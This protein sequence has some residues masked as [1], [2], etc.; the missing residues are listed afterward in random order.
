MYKDKLTKSVA[1]SV[2]K[3]MQEAEKNEN[4][5]PFEG[6]KKVKSSTVV[7]KSGAVHSP[8]SRVKHLA[9]LA[10]QKKKEVKEDVEQIDE[11]SSLDQLHS[12]HKFVFNKTAA[13]K[14]REQDRNREELKQ[15]IKD[16]KRLG[17]IAGPKTKLPEE[18]EQ[19]DELSLGTKIKAYA[20]RSSRQYD[21]EEHGR[22]PEKTRASIVK[23]HGEKAGAHADA[24]ADRAIFGRAPK[25]KVK[26]EVEV[27]EE[28][29]GNQHKI[30]MNKNNKVDAHDFKLLRS[31][32][33]VAEENEE[34]EEMTE[35]WNE[36]MADVKRRHA[37]GQSNFE[38]KKISTGTVYQRKHEGQKEEPTE[39]KKTK[40]VKKYSEMV[41]IIRDKGIKGLDEAFEVEEIVEEVDQIEEQVENQIEERTLTEPEA[42]EKEKIVKGMKKKLS[43]FKDRYGDRAKEV[44]YATATARAK[45]DK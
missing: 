39:T 4:K 45:E 7:D 36:M 29:K 2:T 27:S 37:E 5:P 40:K 9:R 41:E 31:K 22:D 24:A 33:K 13:G 35:G 17:G 43:S 6:G 23:K 26:E 18:V 30:D 8:M 10:M 11:R 21:G 20:Q 42:T 32:K 12:R 1:E 19:I 38:K 3:V 14:K 28:L 25:N 16:T 15:Q 44:M 34:T